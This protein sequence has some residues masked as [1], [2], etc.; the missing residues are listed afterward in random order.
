MPFTP[1][2]TELAEKLPAHHAVQLNILVII[3]NLVKSI[4][5]LSQQEV[6]VCRRIVQLLL[7]NTRLQIGLRV[8][9]PFQFVYHVIVDLRTILM[10]F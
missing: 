10:T 5:L 4:L 3:Y 1:L 8:P 2:S 6:V 9:K 7:G